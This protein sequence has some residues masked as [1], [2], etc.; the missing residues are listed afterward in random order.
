MAA[1]VW[2]SRK[3]AVRFTTIL[4]WGLAITATCALP[5][6][7]AA[8]DQKTWSTRRYQVQIHLAFD[9]AANPGSTT[10]QELQQQL[11]QNIRL[12]IYPLW[13]CE[14]VG[15]SGA[16]RQVMLQQIDNNEKLSEFNSAGF[17]KHLYLTVQGTGLGWKMVCREYDK[18]TDRWTPVLAAEIKQDMVLAESC[19]E[20]ICRTFSP[21]AMIRIDP[22][23]AEHVHLDF[24]GAELP[25]QTDEE[26]FIKPSTVFETL[27]LRRQRGAS[28]SHQ[29]MVSIPWTY[30]V[31]EESVD[32][33]W[34]AQVFSGNR[35][36]FAMSKRA[37]IEIIA[38]P[39]KEFLPNTRVRFHTSHQ[40]SAGLAGYE[41]FSKEANAKQFLPLGVTDHTGSILVP[42]GKS[43]IT[44]LALRSESQLLA[45]V[46]V[47]PG[48][49]ESI[50]IPISDDAARL[51]VQAALT[52]FK[53]LLV[54]TVARRNILIARIRDQ[55]A[56]GKQQE[57]D[58]LFKQLDELPTRA[59]LNRQLDTI[60][61]NSA[62]KSTNKR[63]QA[64]IDRLIA[65][66]RELLGSFLSNNELLELGSEIR[67]SSAETDKVGTTP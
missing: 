61:N 5:T 52:S 44:L 21:L 18:L 39:L 4:Y 6:M 42:R 23:N 34:T 66:N 41:I 16:S 60:A 63:V 14:I 17:D 32:F 50:N 36:P 11:D 45:Q 58:K 7:G 59:G 26:L 30:V 47:A 43:P 64:K 8:Q 62:H 38:I 27:M 1:L 15:Q 35:R 67:N 12:H 29:S 31:A 48:T 22:D 28:M 57:A 20:L 49:A 25:R 65:D 55:L 13:N 3:H 24:M 51:S 53:E 19:L 37:G 33:S 56:K 46:P 10:A 40:N 2:E 54:D 9:A